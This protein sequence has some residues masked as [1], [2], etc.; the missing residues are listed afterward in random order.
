MVSK[1]ELESL[2]LIFTY[3]NSKFVAVDKN[4]DSRYVYTKEK[5]SNISNVHLPFWLFIGKKNTPTNCYTESF[6]IYYS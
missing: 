2:L 1:I 3:S 6:G 4:A 5:R